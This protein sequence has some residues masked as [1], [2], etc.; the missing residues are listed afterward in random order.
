M[1]NQCLIR[2]EEPLPT[3]KTQDKQIRNLSEILPSLT[4]KSYFLPARKAAILFLVFIRSLVAIRR[5]LRSFP[6]WL[7]WGKIKQP[8]VKQLYVY[9]CTCTKDNTINFNQSNMLAGSEAVT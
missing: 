3:H 8:Y 5:S 1:P 6:D 9:L 7:W 2:G 4:S